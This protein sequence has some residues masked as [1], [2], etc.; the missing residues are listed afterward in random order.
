M[1]PVI[2]DD[3]LSVGVEHIFV[4]KLLQNFEPGLSKDCLRV[5]AG[6]KQVDVLASFSLCE[7]VGTKDK[8]LAEAFPS[9]ASGHADCL[10]EVN[11]EQNVSLI[12]N[13]SIFH[14]LGG[15]SVIQ[16]NTCS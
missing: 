2:P 8:F 15:L 5:K 10:A 6:R 4:P 12:L 3:W 13:E 7:V 11:L 16:A 9:K 14:F 1:F